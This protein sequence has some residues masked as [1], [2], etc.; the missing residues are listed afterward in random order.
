MS[1]GFV[2]VAAARQQEEEFEEEEVMVSLSGLI[3]RLVPVAC[4]DKD[5]SCC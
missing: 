5:N 4:A 1:L 2:I 3:I